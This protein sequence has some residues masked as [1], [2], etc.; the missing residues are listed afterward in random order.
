VS[1]PHSITGL[2][3]NTAYDVWVA[4]T[5]GG[6]TSLYTGPVSFTTANAPQPVASFTIDSA[7]VGN[8]EFYYL[9]AS[10]STDAD[11]YQWSFGN[12]TTGN[13]I[14]DTVGYSTNGVYNITLVVSNACGSD[15][16]TLP[17]DANIGLKE[18]RLGQALSVFPNPTHGRLQVEVD[19]P[20]VGSVNL[21]LT[22][23]SGRAVLERTENAG[24]TTYRTELNLSKLAQGIYL[25]EINTEGMTARRR[26][27]VK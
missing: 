27:N 24:G 11:N 19:L 1:S 6:D 10:A 26:I 17:V 9:D 13:G 22:D 20:K 21:T 14:L 8:I 5:C 4:D 7:I 3:P 12:G 25:L 16:L 2:N 18:N 15:T 23:A